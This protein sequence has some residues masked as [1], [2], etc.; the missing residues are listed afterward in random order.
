MWLDTDQAEAQKVLL[1]DA[2]FRALVVQRS[3]AYVKKSQE[4]HGGNQVI[5]PVREQPQ[6]ARYSLKI[7]YGRLLEMVE[8]AF[9]K[10]KPL[11]SLAMYYPLA[12]S[13][14]PADTKDVEAAFQY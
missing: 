9:S 8:K 14:K 6:V 4:Q 7:V 5:F 13:K 3:R 12:Y 10:D 2:L 1:N 11:F